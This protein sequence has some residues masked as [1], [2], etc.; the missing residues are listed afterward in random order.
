M[1]TTLAD[2]ADVDRGRD[3]DRHRRLRRAGVLPLALSRRVRVRA[4]DGRAAVERYAETAPR[5]RRGD[6]RFPHYVAGAWSMTTPLMQAFGGELLA[7]EGAEG[8]YA[9]ALAPSLASELTER[10]RSPMMCAIGIALKIDDGSMTRGR[11]PGDHEDARAPRHRRSTR[12]RSCSASATGRCAIVAGTLV[13]EVRA[14]FE[15]EMLMKRCEQLLLVAARS[16][17]CSPP[18]APSASR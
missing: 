17:S 10:L 18:A 6:D 14:E 7:K 1:R 4:A 2:F 12:D 15:L 3:P 13:G 16:A 11:N 9:M 8:F 5:R